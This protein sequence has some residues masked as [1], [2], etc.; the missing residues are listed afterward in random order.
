VASQRQAILLYEDEISSVEG[1]DASAGD[2]EGT[3]RRTH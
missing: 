2:P 3:A 1:P